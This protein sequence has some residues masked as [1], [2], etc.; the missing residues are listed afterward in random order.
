MSA[1][2]CACPMATAVADWIRGDMAPLVQALAPLQPHRLVSREPSLSEVFLHLY[3]AEP[4]GEHD[5]DDD[6]GAPPSPGRSR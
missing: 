1:T 6:G 3:G 5:R 4:D 2:A